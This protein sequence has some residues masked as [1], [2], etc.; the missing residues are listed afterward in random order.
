M[1]KNDADF[2]VVYYEF[3]LKARWATMNNP[4]NKEPYF[5]K[6]QS[7][8]PEDSLIDILNDLKEEMASQSYELSLGSKHSIRE[9]IHHLFMI[10]KSEII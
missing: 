7:I 9:I 3:Y 1:G 8:S 5:Q 2:Q 4:N 6:L 10:E